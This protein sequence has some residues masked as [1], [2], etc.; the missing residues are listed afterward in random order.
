M[1][2][3]L[4]IPIQQCQYESCNKDHSSTKPERKKLRKKKCPCITQ[5]YRHK[6]ITVRQVKL[7][8]LKAMLKQVTR[9]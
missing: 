1:A 7:L 9:D 2:N 3:Y 6:E 5:R 8:S 4:Y